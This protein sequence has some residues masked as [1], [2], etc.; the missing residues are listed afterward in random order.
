MLS[1]IFIY[2]LSKSDDAEDQRLLLEVHSQHAA[3]LSK[4]LTLYKLRAAVKITSAQYQVSIFC[5]N[6]DY[7]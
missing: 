2:N 1:D 5:V 4:F 3:E 6:F 7:G